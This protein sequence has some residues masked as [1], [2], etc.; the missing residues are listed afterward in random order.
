ML[1]S[2]C[3]FHILVFTILIIFEIL[4]MSPVY[5][6]LQKYLCIIFA[7]QLLCVS[8]F[9]HAKDLAGLAGKSSISH[10]IA[11][12]MPQKMPVKRPFHPGHLV[13]KAIN[14]HPYT[15][16]HSELL[17]ELYT[18]DNIQY[19]SP[20]ASVVLFSSQEINLPPPKNIALNDMWS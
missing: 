3:F 1:K 18:A 4:N 17:P 11:G 19:P 13:Y 6:I 10:H 5:K 9:F 12:N 8:L 20:F 7:V 16:S 2:Y 15:P 14:F